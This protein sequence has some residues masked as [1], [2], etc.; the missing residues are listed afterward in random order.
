M[1]RDAPPC[2]APLSAL[3]RAN[4]EFI[5]LWLNPDPSSPYA[6]ET[7][8]SGQG[9]GVPKNIVICCDGTGNEIGS[10]ISNVLKLYQVLDKTGDQRVYYTPGV[11]TIGLQS[12]WQ[13]WKQLVQGVFGLATGYGLDDDVLGA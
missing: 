9:R 4:R 12:A 2:G 5:N 8:D 10:N 3:N 11:G 7:S 1:V 13:R 6:D